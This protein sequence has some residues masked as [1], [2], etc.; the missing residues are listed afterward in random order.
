M[1]SKKRMEHPQLLQSIIISMLSVGILLLGF[2][3]VASA[4]PTARVEVM[5]DTG[6]H[7]FSVEVMSSPS[8]RAKGLMFRQSLPADQG[9]LFDFAENVTI[10]MWMKNTYIPLDMIF[11]DDTGT[12]IDIAENTVPHSTEIISSAAPARYV[13]EVIAGSSARINARIGD[14]IITHY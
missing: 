7:T 5:T 8:E 6:T 2:A 9:M 14:R 13:L 12:I 1:T 4:A 3:T 10:R 11:I